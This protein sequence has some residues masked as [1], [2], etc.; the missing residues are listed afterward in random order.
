MTDAK[1]GDG[2]IDLDKLAKLDKELG[3]VK[4]DKKALKK[5]LENPACGPT[6]PQPSATP[7]SE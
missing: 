7:P 1:G 6:S 2:R 3:G 4:P 5:I